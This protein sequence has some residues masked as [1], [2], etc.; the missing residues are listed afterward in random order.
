M[1]REALTVRSSFLNKSVTYQLMFILKPLRD[2][3]LTASTRQW[4]QLLRNF[5]KNVNGI[6]ASGHVGFFRVADGQND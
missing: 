1:P 6:V 5:L 3:G 4:N 2:V